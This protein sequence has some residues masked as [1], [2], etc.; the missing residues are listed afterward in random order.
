VRRVLL[1][2]ALA[3]SSSP[4]FAQSAGAQAEVLFDDGR[5]LLADGKTAEACM[6]FEESQKLE[7]A[8]TTLIALATCREKNGQ[9]ATAW[10]L[11]LDAERQTRAA[12]DT[13]NQQLNDIAQDRATKLAPRVSKLTIAVGDASRINGLTITRDNDSVDSPLWNK[14]LPIDGGTYTVT[15]RAPGATPWSAT[16]TLAVE[17]ENTTVDVPRLTTGAQSNAEPPVTTTANTPP[18]PTLATKTTSTPT[19]TAGTE[20]RAQRSLVLPLSFAGG[21]LVLGGVG[22]AF[23]LSAESAY[24][25]AKAATENKPRDSDYSSANSERHLAQGFGVGGV[26]CAG[27]AVWL[28]LRGRHAEDNRTSVI[29]TPGGITVLGKF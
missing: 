9:L 3:A 11:F 13:N 21:A 16:V 7:P 14:A 6:S 23:E 8:T 1:V 22:L 17:G 24:S 25:D 26:L 20:P 10:G 29:A 28:Y 5:K 12:V 19:A 2:V 15:A 18:T 4:V 27:A